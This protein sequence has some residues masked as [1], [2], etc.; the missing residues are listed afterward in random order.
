MLSEKS[1]NLPSNYKIICIYMVFHFGWRSKSTSFP[2]NSY[3]SDHRSVGKSGHD[4][5]ATGVF[6]KMSLK[7]RHSDCQSKRESF[8]LVARKQTWRDSTK[9]V[10]QISPHNKLCTKLIEAHFYTP[11]YDIRY[12]DTNLLRGLCSH[13]SN[14][15]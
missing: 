5:L 9:M 8:R 12:T 14:H 3:R 10:L 6:A 15:A 4:E 1:D 13:E 11:I 2:L 7:F